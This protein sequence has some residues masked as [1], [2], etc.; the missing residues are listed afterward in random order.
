MSVPK[1]GTIEIDYLTGKKFI[2][3]NGELRPIKGE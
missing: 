3:V 2:W 1:D